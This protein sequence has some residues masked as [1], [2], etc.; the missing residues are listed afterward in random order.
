MPHPFP[1]GSWSRVAIWNA[2]SVFCT[3]APKLKAACEH[4]AGTM[5][6]FSPDPRE[7]RLSRHNLLVLFRCKLGNFTRLVRTHSFFFL[8][9]HISPSICHISQQIM[10]HILV[11]GY[12]GKKKT[13]LVG[14]HSHSMQFS[15]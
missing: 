2:V 7:Q 12:F 5:G 9:S 8:P 4:R 1:K 14:H 6:V 11:Q 10:C 3:I 13:A 15:H